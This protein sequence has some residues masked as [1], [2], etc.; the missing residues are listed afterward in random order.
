[1]DPVSA[2]TIF[3][4]IAPTVFGF[5]AE[6]RRKDPE[7][8]YEQILQQAGVKLDAEHQ[9]LLADMAKAVSEGAVPR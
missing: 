6:M 1:M 9:R 2:I 3:N 5:I 8:T 4:I 7:L